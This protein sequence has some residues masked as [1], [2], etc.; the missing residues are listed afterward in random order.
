MLQTY[1][2]CKIKFN[3]FFNLYSDIEVN[4]LVNK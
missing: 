4:Y 2:V 1:A 3:V